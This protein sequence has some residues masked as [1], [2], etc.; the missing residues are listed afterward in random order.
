MK[1]MTQLLTKVI[2]DGHREEIFNNL[3]EKLI[4]N[5]DYNDF[6]AKNMQKVVISMIKSSTVS[7]SSPNEG[8]L[9]PKNADI[10]DQN[11]ENVSEFKVGMIDLVNSI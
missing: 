5:N 4:T 2:V 7:E 11:D 3:L 6:I 9:A 10:E 1:T 8:D